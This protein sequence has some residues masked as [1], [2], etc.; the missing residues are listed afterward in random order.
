MGEKPEPIDES[1]DQPMKRSRKGSDDDEKPADPDD[2]DAH[3]EEPEEP[4]H[5]ESVSLI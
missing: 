4:E 3:V 5:E 1:D 2:V